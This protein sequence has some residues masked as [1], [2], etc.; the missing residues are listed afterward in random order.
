[1]EDYGNIS[2]F[3]KSILEKKDTKIVG[4]FLARYFIF[5]NDK[6]LEDAIKMCYG[7]MNEEKFF[8]VLR[9]AI[10]SDKVN[11][12]QIMEKNNF[13]YDKE[14]FK[15]LAFSWKSKDCIDF[16]IN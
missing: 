9:S 4:A 12:F 8:D 7:V 13:T 16:F 11:V 6:V 14:Y 10:Y 2:A 5:Q 15:Q 1:M 3:A